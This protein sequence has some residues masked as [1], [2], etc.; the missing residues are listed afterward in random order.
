MTEQENILQQLKKSVLVF[1]IETSSTYP[2]GEVI[3]I[4][5]NFE[6]YVKYAKCKWFGA[7]SYKDHEIYLLNVKKDKDKILRLLC[8][9]NILVGFNSEDFDYPILTN[10]KLTPIN[11]KYLQ[12][13]CMT[14]LGSSVYRTKSGFPY[15]NR[16]EL[17][18]YKFKRNSLKAIAEEMKLPSQ[19]GE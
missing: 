5:T 8:T 1:D 7:Y 3:N 6:D 13:D 11:K 2:S 16:G 18:D 12:V 14:I 19:K 10:N 4:K 17:M 15:K 9:H